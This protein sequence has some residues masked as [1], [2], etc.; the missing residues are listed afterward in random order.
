MPSIQGGSI[1]DMYLQIDYT[2]TQN[3]SNNTST[4]R[5]TLKLVNHYA[6]YMTTLGGSYLSVGGQKVDYS[7]LSLAMGVLRCRSGMRVSYSHSVDDMCMGAGRDAGPIPAEQAQQQRC[8]I[9]PQYAH[10]ISI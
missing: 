9:F 4:V 1:R 5:A 2:V 3:V 10:Y 6:L 8:E 7:E